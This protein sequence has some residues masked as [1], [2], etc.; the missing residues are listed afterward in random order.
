MTISRQTH[1]NTF[2]STGLSRK[3]KK[4]AKSKECLLVRRWLP[5]IRN[6]VYWSATTS[7]SAPE[8]VAK[9]KSLVNHIQNV[10][11]HDDPLFPTCAHP[12]RVSV[13]PSKWFQ[14]G[15]CQ[16]IRASHTCARG[17]QAESL[18]FRK[19]PTNKMYDY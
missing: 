5:S 7:T 1:A 14:P 12:N 9:W 4:L 2:F 10:H 16:P 8:K 11:T 19:V 3:L 18:G 15:E 13:D 17:P 6:H